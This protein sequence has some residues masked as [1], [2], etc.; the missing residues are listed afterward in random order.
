MER[1]G[2][3]SDNSLFVD[4]DNKD[5]L[6][7]DTPSDFQNFLRENN[8]PDSGVTLNKDQIEVLKN[9]GVKG[10]L[11]REDYA[12]QSRNELIVIDDSIIK[13]ISKEN[14]EITQLPSSFSDTKL[15]SEAYVNAKAD[16]SNPELIKAVD[17]FIASGENKNLQDT[18]KQTNLAAD[19]TGKPKAGNRLFNE[20]L[21]AVAE[22]ANRY[23]QR[24]FGSQRPTFEGTTELDVERAKRIAAAYEAMENNPNDPE[25]RRAYEA[26]AKETID[27]YQDF[28]DAGYIVEINNEEPYANSAD[29][30]EDLRNNNR[31]KIFST[32]AGFGDEPIT[33]KQR[34][35]NPLLAITEFTDV[36]GQPMLVNDFFRAVHDFFGHAELGYSFGPKGEE[37]AWNVHARMYSP[38]ARR[39]MTTETRGQNSYVNFSGVNEKADKLREKARKLREG[40]K[41][42]EAIKELEAVMS[43]E[44]KD[45]IEAKTD[46]LMKA[47]QKLGEKVYA[48]SAQDGAGAGSADAGASASGGSS[49]SKADAEDVVD[50]DFKEVKRD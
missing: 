16:G 26:M 2:R 34:A 40:G 9:L 42:E 15:I 41:I 13:N 30:I 36:N 19:E 50:A 3:E 23:F 49:G 24:V 27:Q 48:Q 8:L 38:L 47:S 32:E 12:S 46:N 37:N 11:L 45:T 20:P 10:I 17:D 39:A 7:F 14:K 6:Y 18:Q 31:I 1:F 25:V 44:D 35:E 43:G 22:I 21:K 28:L 33:P 5:L 4:I 29:M